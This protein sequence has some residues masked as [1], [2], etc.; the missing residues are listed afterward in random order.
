MHA[1]VVAGGT[2]AVDGVLLASAVVP[3]LIVIVLCRIAW[4]W[5]KGDEEEA[6]ASPREVIRRAFWLSARGTKRV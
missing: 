6:D 4:V 5:A 2:G 1:L 3:P